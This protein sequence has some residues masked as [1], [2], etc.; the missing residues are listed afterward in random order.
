MAS[1]EYREL[2][3]RLFLQDTRRLAAAS[4]RSHELSL[5]SDEYIAAVPASGLGMPHAGADLHDLCWYLHD[6]IKHFLG[7]SWRSRDADSMITIRPHMIDESRWHMTRQQDLE[8]WLT[9]KLCNTTTSKF[10]Q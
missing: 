2:V 6:S 1:S 3:R 5:P 10:R 9:G 4:G 8:I 7:I